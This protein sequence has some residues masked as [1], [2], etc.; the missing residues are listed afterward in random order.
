MGTTSEEFGH[1]ERVHFVRLG[2][3]N[4]PRRAAIDSVDDAC[5]LWIKSGHAYVGIL[6]EGIDE[7]DVGI[8]CCIFL[9]D[10]LLS[11]LSSDLS[12]GSFTLMI[13]YHS[14]WLGYY[15]DVI[16]FVEDTEVGTIS[17]LK[18]FDIILGVGRCL[19]TFPAG[20]GIRFAIL[21]PS[22]LLGQPPGLVQHL[23][24]SIN[25][26]IFT[27]LRPSHDGMQRA[28]NQTVADQVGMY[29]L[30]FRHVFP[31]IDQ[32]HCSLSSSDVVRII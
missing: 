16:V 20:P 8:N 13:T 32:L 9:F 29:P 6:D 30:L 5:R 23:V 11:L 26:I 21:G 14:R 18:C 27:I 24:G 19:S 31:R 22:H 12:G 3:D 15:E 1:K 17:L 10:S 28:V 25:E 7:A 2:Q 4:A